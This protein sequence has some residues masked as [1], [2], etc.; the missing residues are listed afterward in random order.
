[1]AKAYASKT[2]AIQVNRQFL[3]IVAVFNHQAD[4]SV[5]HKEIRMY[6]DDPNITVESYP[7][8]EPRP[9][10]QPEPP[11][12]SYPDGVTGEE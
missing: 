1:M 10:P 6:G 7:G 8:A 12:P 2:K 9:E 5:T 3:G 4:G 11:S